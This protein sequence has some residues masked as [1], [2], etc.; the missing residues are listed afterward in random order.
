MFSYSLPVLIHL[1]FLV[2]YYPKWCYDII[3]RTLLFSFFFDKFYSFLEKLNKFL[4]IFRE[5]YEI[6]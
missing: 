5:L 6:L 1:D 4:E 2:M 3:D